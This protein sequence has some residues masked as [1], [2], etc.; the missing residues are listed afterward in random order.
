MKKL[1]KLPKIDFC[2]WVKDNTALDTLAPK[3]MISVIILG[4]F[5]G[6]LLMVAE[7]CKL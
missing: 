1:K 7:K 6:F 2:T 4:Y 3:F 5:M